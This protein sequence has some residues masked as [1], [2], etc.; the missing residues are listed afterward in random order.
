MI[1]Q[2]QLLELISVPFEQSFCFFILLHRA[3]S[4]RADCVDGVISVVTIVCV[5]YDVYS[6]LLNGR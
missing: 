1:H 2:G 4:P 6:D 3:D 5:M